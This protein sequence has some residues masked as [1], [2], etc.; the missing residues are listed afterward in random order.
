MKIQEHPLYGG[1]IKTLLELLGV[2]DKEEL[3]TAINGGYRVFKIPKKDGKP[4]IVEAPNK[5][6]KII[7]T[8]F[9]KLLQLLDCPE[10]N[11]CGWKK[12]NTL[13]NVKKH[14]KN[15]NAYLVAD[16]S[17]YYPNTK[18]QYVREFFAKFNTDIETLDILVKLTTFHKHLPT[19]A[20]T[21]SILVF[22]S[23]KEL[24]DKINAKMQEEEITF[25][26]YAD[27]MTFS[28]KHGITN[29]NLRY[30]RSI[31]AKHH[32]QAKPEKSK[33][34]SYKKANITGYY[35]LQNGKI[36]VSFSQRHKVIKKLKEKSIYEMTEK[37]L[38]KLL[39]KINYIHA[40]DNK[41]FKITRIKVIKRLKQ[42]YAERFISVILGYSQHIIY[43]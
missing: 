4:R 37:E 23:H 10:Y 33:H 12:Q 1:T 43:H 42:L 38:M 18:A 16:I 34:Y 27:D 35:L 7:L 8:K 41:A 9:V 36:D 25:S 40:I 28:S 31:L 15:A 30:V 13:M 24:F 5:Q 20:P 3:I 11:Y 6:L 29:Q 14:L 22:L 39:G 32:L 2:N 17:K 19:G 21:S 26:L